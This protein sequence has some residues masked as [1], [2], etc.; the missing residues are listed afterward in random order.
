MKK[1]NNNMFKG[2]TANLL[3]YIRIICLEKHNISQSEVSRHCSIDQRTVSRIEGHECITWGPMLNVFNYYCH[4]KG[5]KEKHA[6]FFN[7][8][9]HTSRIPDDVLVLLTDEHYD[10]SKIDEEYVQIYEEAFEVCK[11]NF[12]SMDKK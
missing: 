4:F 6:G 9:H 11:I 5:I 2:Q 10:R 7:K 12:F 8:L 1:T 3:H